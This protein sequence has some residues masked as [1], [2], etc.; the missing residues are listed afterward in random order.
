MKKWNVLNELVNNGV[1]AVIRGENKNHAISII[2]QC[3]EGGIVTIEVTYTTKNATEVIQYFSELEKTYPRLL[4][5]A[6]TVL[7]Q[8]TARIAILAGAKFI[9]SP[10]FDINTAKLCN[11]YD[12]PYIPGIAT[13]KEAVAA[14]EYGSS[15]LKVFPGELYGPKMIKA[16]KGPLPHVNLMPTGGVSIENMNEW[17]DAGAVA[18]GIG[19]A[20]TPKDNNANVVNIAH[21]ITQRYKEL[22]K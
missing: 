18:V 4:L 16:I 7:D 12:V 8:E 14:M 2:E 22:N 9:V 3:L 1:V 15:I 20:L 5:G 17:I 6:G 19:G 13:V 21:T 11:R 10:H